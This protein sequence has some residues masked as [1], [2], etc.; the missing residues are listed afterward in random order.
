MT[1]KSKISSM[2]T[3]ETRP[4]WPYSYRNTR[5]MYIILVAYKNN[6]QIPEHHLG[7]F[8]IFRYFEIPEHHLALRPRDTSFPLDFSPL[9]YSCQRVLKVF[10]VTAMYYDLFGRALYGDTFWPPNR[11]FNAQKSRQGELARR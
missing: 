8:E 4:F 5:Y 6:T 10:Y 2:T 1:L 9:H 11:T 3:I 7:C